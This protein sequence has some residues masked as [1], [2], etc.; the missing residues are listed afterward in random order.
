[1]QNEL[2]RCFA[3]VQSH[4]H[5]YAR[6]RTEVQT[7][8]ELYSMTP[9]VLPHPH[10]MTRLIT[11]VGTIGITFRRTNY[12]VPL[13]IMFPYDYPR[14][15]PNFFTDPTPQMIVVPGHPYAFP[16]RTIVH[17][18]LV[19]W[20][21]TQSTL[22]VLTLLQREFSLFPP[23]RT[24]P[25]RPAPVPFPLPP[26]PLRPPPPGPPAFPKHPAFRSKRRPALPELER[27]LIDGDI[28]PEEFAALYADHRQQDAP[29]GSRNG[30]EI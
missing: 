15:P 23:L 19:D 16:D 26:L 10:R 2:D 11:V 21:Q 8:V 13:L 17:P 6:V 9:V 27:M 7:V 14:S 20:A 4:Y 29:F 18:S 12:N 22:N 3:G 25:P 5:C 30:G 24:R 28:T 1:M